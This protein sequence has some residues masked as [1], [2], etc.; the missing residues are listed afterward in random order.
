[1]K[2]EIKM[3][4]YDI[5]TSIDSIFEFVGEERNFFEYQRKTS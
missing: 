1:M 5:K 3:H 2:H 4:L